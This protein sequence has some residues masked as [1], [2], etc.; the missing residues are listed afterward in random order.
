M[1]LYNR[2]KYIKSQIEFQRMVYSFPGQTFADTIQFYLAMSFLGM[3]HHPEAIGEF[4]KFLQAYPTSPLADDAQYY[5]G[6]SHYE[7][8]PK[9]SLEQTESYAAIDEF[10]MFL[11]KYP[12]SELADDAREKLNVLYD[13]MA[14]KLFKAGHLYLKMNDY[15]PALL[16]FLNV[17]DNYPSTEW[18]KYSLYYTGETQMKLGK[19]PEALEAFQNFVSA[20][21]DD[22]LISKARK[23]ITKL[24]GKTGGG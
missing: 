12:S 9:Y 6:I 17:R 8:S 20:F 3:E 4:K 16:Y 19:Y 14:K 13:K 11:S 1:D 7:Q 23:N 24:N 21:P 10:S 18:A 2:G 5:C 15:E 22:K